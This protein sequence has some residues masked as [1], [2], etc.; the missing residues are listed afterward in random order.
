MAKSFHPHY[1]LRIRRVTRLKTEEIK[2]QL[3]LLPRLLLNFYENRKDTY[4]A[5]KGTKQQAGTC[6]KLSNAETNHFS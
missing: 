6:K 1:T 4:D 3:I 2:T 5:L